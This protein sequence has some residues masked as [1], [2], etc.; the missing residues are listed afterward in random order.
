MV[1]E[2]NASP[3]TGFEPARVSPTD[4]FNQKNNWVLRGFKSGPLT[5]RAQRHKTP[6]PRFSR[7]P[8]RPMGAF[9]KISAYRGKTTRLP[10]LTS[11]F[12]LPQ[13]V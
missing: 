6:L 2:Q 5:T 10:I 1:S 13:P 11:L 3:P 7:H 9:R 8:I 12:H 4:H